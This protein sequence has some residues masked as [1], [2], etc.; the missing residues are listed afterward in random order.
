VVN[1]PV[2]EMDIIRADGDFRGLSEKIGLMVR[3]LFSS[4]SSLIPTS[5]QQLYSSIAKNTLTIQ[6]PTTKGGI[7]FYIY[8]YT[9]RIVYILEVK[10]MP[11]AC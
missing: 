7:I 11:R 3:N 9:I 1:I 8:F 4:C 5:Q 2:L 6:Y 10:V